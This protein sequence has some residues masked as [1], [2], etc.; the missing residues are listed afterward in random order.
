MAR[1]STDAPDLST[2][3][4][5]VAK[6]VARG[7]KREACTCPVFPDKQGRRAETVVMRKGNMTKSGAITSS[8]QVCE[9]VN[10][11]ANRPQEE[12]IALHLNNK[13]EIIAE[14][15]V[16]KGTPTGATVEPSMVFQPALLSNAARVILV[17]NHPSGNPHPSAS[18]AA[19]T[20]RVAEVGK[21]LAI[22][23]LDHIVVGQWQ[24]KHQCTSLRDL[25]IFKG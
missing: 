18:D 7:M 10:A 12:V 22:P 14:S 17:H 2:T 6:K 13:N 5:G 24:G 4:R 15:L 9:W 16:A 20:N 21:L 23:V 25:G 8:G 19:F 11:Q 1:Y 3:L